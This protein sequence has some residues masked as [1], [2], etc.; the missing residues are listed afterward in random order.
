MSPQ[1]WPSRVVV[2]ADVA[3]PYATAAEWAAGRLELDVAPEEAPDPEALNIGPPEF[4]SRCPDAGE[5]VRRAPAGRTWEVMCATPAGGRVVTGSSPLAAARAALDAV[6]R[7]LR[8]E[9]PPP[10][11]LLRTRVFESLAM[12][13]DDWSAGFHRFADGFDMPRHVADAVRVGVETLEVNLLADVVP[14]QVKQRRVHED[15]YPW[16]SIYCPALDM[17]VES[18]LSRGTYRR[19]LLDRNLARL[20]ET[21]ELARSWGLMPSF[22]AFEPRAWP[23]R[24]FDKH[25]ELRGAR[26]DCSDYSAEP[27]YAP[28]PNHPLVQEHYRQMMQRL[29]EQVPDLGLFSVWSQDSCAGFPWAQRLY[30][31]PNGP[32]GARKRRVE[33][34]VVNLMT[35]L[36]DGGRAVN[37]D[38]Q[39]TVCLSWF[40]PG[41][42]EAICEA[43]PDDIGASFTVAAEHERPRRGRRDWTAIQRIRAHGI[44]PQVQL[45]EIAN[46]WKPLGPMLGFP[47]P[48]LAYDQLTDAQLRGEVKDLILRGGVQT[49]VF[50]PNYINNEVIRAFSL[51][52]SALNVERLVERRAEQWTQDG[53]EARALLNAWR[54]CDRV[55]RHCQVLAWTVTFVSGRTLWRRLV[56]P[57]VPDQSLLEYEDYGWYRQFEF[58]VGRTDPA[59]IDHFFKGWTRMVDDDAARESLDTYDEQLLPRLQEAVV[60]LE[61]CGELSETARDV[62]DRAQCM[63]HALTTER[64]LVEVQEAIHACLAEDREEPE[65]SRHADR[66]RAAVEGEMD[67]TRG[68]I[69]LLRESPSTLIP[70]TSGIETTFMLRAPLWYL[71][72]LKL[73]AME[74]HIDDPPGPWFDELLQPGGWTSDLTLPEA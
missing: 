36:R 46:P 54:L 64:N 72:E 51:E 2:A 24:L 66:L 10:E 55:F 57:L 16:W 30:A 6:D 42:V 29:M 62:R 38:L 69:E 53:D 5:A 17:F 43:L 11:P 59:W 13:F 45:E 22:V 25:P 41:E 21:A 58:T 39:F 61:G 71:L 28:D 19:E 63:L 68:F 60:R 32:R 65:T 14:V 31:G 20:K 52:G 56:K 49:E 18:D 23:E 15:M 34:G 7:L 35:A 44:E 74:R 33:E 67:N 3:Q 37:P 73:A 47:F 27:E 12:E 9:P 70:A 50:V 8:E 40:A 1:R 48:Y 4:A 26:V